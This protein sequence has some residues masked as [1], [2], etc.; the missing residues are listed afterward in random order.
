MYLVVHCGSYIVELCSYQRSKNS[1]LPSRFTNPTGDGLNFT[2]VVRNFSMILQSRV[3]KMKLLDGSETAGKVYAH[4]LRDSIYR[5]R[6]IFNNDGRAWSTDIE[7]PQANYFEA[8]ITAGHF[9]FNNEEILMC[10]EK[11]LKWIQKLI[12]DHVSAIMM[13]TGVSNTKEVSYRPY[14]RSSPETNLCFH[15]EP[16]MLLILQLRF[17]VVL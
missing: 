4:S 13:K 5:I 7:I 3:Q 2:S 6:L 16:L 17:L 9:T 10:F 15:S 12:D 1:Q 11:P 14:A 8:G